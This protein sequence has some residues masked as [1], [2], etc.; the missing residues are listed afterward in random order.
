MFGI[1]LGS[2][3]LLERLKCFLDVEVLVDSLCI[4]GVWGCFL[5][6]FKCNIKMFSEFQKIVFELVKVVSV[7][8][9]CIFG[10]WG[11]DGVIVKMVVED[12]LS[13]DV[14]IQFEVV[15]IVNSV[16]YYDDD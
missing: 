3:S 9:V 1:F 12:S 16:K 4:L 6:V 13:Y 8:V 14:V 15:R 7:V 10:L 5:L 11:C 2:S